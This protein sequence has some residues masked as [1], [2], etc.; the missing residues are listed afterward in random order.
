VAKLSGTSRML[1]QLQFILIGVG[2]VVQLVIILTTAQLIKKLVKLLK[3][4]P[5][6]VGITFHLYPKRFLQRLVLGPL[7]TKSPSLSLLKLGKRERGP[8]SK[9][10]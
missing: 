9:M 4:T 3:I 2:R 10:T 7:D 5:S 1:G 6:R 8:N